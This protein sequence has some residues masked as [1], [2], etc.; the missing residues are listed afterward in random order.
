ME[1]GIRPLDPRSVADVESAARLH[2]LLLPRSPLSQLGPEF[3]RH[4][5]YRTLIE[6][7]LVRCDLYNYRGVAVG[8]IAYT[9]YPSDFMA[10]GLRRHCF[11]LAALMAGLRL[12]GTTRPPGG[13]AGVCTVERVG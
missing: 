6:D 5:Y 10:R 12:R 7:G 9:K 11:Y 3:M 8:F 2:S 4:F 1:D 13:V